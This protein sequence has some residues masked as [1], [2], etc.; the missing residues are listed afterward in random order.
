MQKN[1]RLSGVL[2]L[3]VAVLLFT[4]S[5]SVLLGSDFINNSVIKKSPPKI[6]LIIDDVGNNQ[7]L[8]L[9]AAKLPPEVALSILPHT[10]FSNEIASLGH[11]RGMDILLHQPMESVSNVN[12]L[13]P[14]SLLKNM[15]LSVRTRT[16]TASWLLAVFASIDGRRSIWQMT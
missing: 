14:G 4:T 7:L 2:S 11:Q 3:L 1:K 15:P 16:N 10:S 12:L 13:G 8:G 6:T 5:S 9:R